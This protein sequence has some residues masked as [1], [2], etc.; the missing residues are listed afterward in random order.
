MLRFGQNFRKDAVMRE[1]TNVMVSSNLSNL[2]AWFRENSLATKS[3]T[4]IISESSNA[5]ILQ[6]TLR[7]DSRVFMA[8]VDNG[9]LLVSELYEVSLYPQTKFSFS[10]YL[11]SKH[12]GEQ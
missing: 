11:L 7:L 10:Q 9:S 4:W 6:G 1:G 3:S 8:S 5:D 12:Q 2:A